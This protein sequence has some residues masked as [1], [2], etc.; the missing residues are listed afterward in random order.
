M[1]NITAEQAREN[2][3]EFQSS[4][5][6]KLNSEILKSFSENVARVSK[7][8]KTST[9]VLSSVLFPQV[10]MDEIRDAGFYIARNN[11]NYSPFGY[12]VSWE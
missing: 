1:L 2:A 7:A 3:S 4:L 9:G 8:G 12:D 5:T 10:V 6:S 11:K